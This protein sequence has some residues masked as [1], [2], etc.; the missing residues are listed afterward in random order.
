[1]DAVPY[2]CLMVAAALIYLPRVVAARE[3]VKQQG[4]YDNEEPRRAQALLEGMGRRAVAAHNNSFEAFAPFAAGVLACAQR[5]VEVA[6][7]AWL[8]IGFVALR[9]G[10]L[11]AYLA[12][13]STIRSSLWF[14][15]ISISGA[16]LLLAAI[17]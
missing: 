17:G 10:Y 11:V 14:A 6:L 4:R 1:M 8:S 15:A 5:G 2:V 12:N 16:L 7:V 3:I 13:R 9:G